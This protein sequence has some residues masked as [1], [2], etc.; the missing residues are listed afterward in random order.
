VTTPPRTIL[1][2]EDEEPVLTLVTRLL[3]DQGYRTLEARDGAQALHL[4]HL[5]IA[6]L[7]LVITDVMMP[8]MDGRE[9]GRRLAQS[10]PDL[11]VLYISGYYSG[12]VF[13]RDGAGTLSSFLHK[14]FSDIDLL[15]KVKDLL[16]ASP[17]Q[18]RVP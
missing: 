8:R 5:S 6:Y 12:D 16:I 9:L 7:D 1:V 11:P 10:C 18:P 3:W 14:P 17:R 13:H 15:A 4:A 2:V